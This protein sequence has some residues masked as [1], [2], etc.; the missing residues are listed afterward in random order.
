MSMDRKPHLFADVPAT[1]RTRRDFLRRAGG[2]FG[3]LA[4]A[5][6]L[7]QQDLLAASPNPQ[8]PIRNPQSGIDPAHPLAP[9]RGHF[10]H[11]LE[12]RARGAPRQDER[13]P[14]HE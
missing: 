7:D 6:L 3:L 1:Y 2:G 4:L 12:V 5:S 8:S 11:Q 10:S 9:R 13:R 14:E